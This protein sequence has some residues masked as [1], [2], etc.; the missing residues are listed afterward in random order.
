MTSRIVR[1]LLAC[2]A[3]IG[4]P[5][6]ALAADDFSSELA[7]VTDVGGGDFTF[8]QG[9]FSDG[10]QVT[11]SFS[12]ADLDG[13]GQ[14]SSFEGELTAFEMSFSGNSVVDGFSLGLDDLFGL[15]YDLDGDIGDGLDFDVEGIAAFAG[16]FTYAMGPGP[17]FE[18]DGGACGVV[19]QTPEPSALALFGLGLLGFG[20][21]RRRAT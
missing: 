20:L 7:I 3:V 10:A 14:I 5:A 18:C 13:N 15:V 11:G 21:T 19:S 12:A 4:V 1:A 17:F 2:V 6:V 9:G 8:V 16:S